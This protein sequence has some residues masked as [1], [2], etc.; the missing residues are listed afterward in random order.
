M[1]LFILVIWGLAGFVLGGVL[2][3]IKK[4]EYLWELQ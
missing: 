1:M 4:V 3:W 2:G